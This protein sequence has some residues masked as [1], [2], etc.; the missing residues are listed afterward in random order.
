MC[1]IVFI[2][3]ENMKIQA[4][5]GTKQSQCTLLVRFLAFHS[6]QL[7]YIYIYVC[8]WSNAHYDRALKKLTMEFTKQEY[9]SFTT[10]SSW[11]NDLLYVLFCAY[12]WFVR[13]KITITS[14]HTDNGWKKLTLRRYRI[15]WALHRCLCSFSFIFQSHRAEFKALS[16]KT[17]KQI[18]DK[19]HYPALKCEIKKAQ[20]CEMQTISAVGGKK[21]NCS[22]GVICSTIE[23]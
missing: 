14:W 7:H 8:V 11:L 6:T 12:F 5:C 4:E 16:Q 19:T 22:L 1:A 20:Q 18:Q 21:L 23:S 9:H 10:G 3:M 17:T 2:I 15:K 13:P